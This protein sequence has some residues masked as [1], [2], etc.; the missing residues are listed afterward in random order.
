M[1]K[2]LKAIGPAVWLAVMLVVWATVYCVLN[3]PTKADP[4]FVLYYSLGVR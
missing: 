4:A 3:P 2:I 1:L